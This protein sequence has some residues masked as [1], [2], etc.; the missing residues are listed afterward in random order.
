MGEFKAGIWFSLISLY[1]MLFIVLVSSSQ[2]F[3]AEI[4]ATSS[5]SVVSGGDVPNVLQ[6]V[7]QEETR[8]VLPRKAYAPDS[9]SYRVSPLSLKCENSAGGIS[10][11]NCNEIAGCTW[12]SVNES[13]LTSIINFITFQSTANETCN[14]Y[15][16]ITS[17]EY[18]GEFVRNPLPN[19][20]ASSKTN[21]CNL[22]N[23]Q[24]SPYYCGLLGCTIESRTVGLSGGTSFESVLSAGNLFSVVGNLITFNYDFGFESEALSLVLTLVFFY[25][26][27][28]LWV[29][30]LYFAIPIIH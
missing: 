17:P 29:V 27:L 28:I 4:N 5:G 9:T 18:G 11:S 14:G 19:A 10:E 12:G 21:V 6:S 2:S 15:I 22:P 30:S 20:F 16:N 25:L 24:D 23:V 8:C 26:P 1:F 13:T 3:G 7:G